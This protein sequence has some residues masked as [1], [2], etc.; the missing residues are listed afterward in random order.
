MVQVNKIGTV[1]SFHLND[2]TSRAHAHS[3]VCIELELKQT[4]PKMRRRAVCYT[5][6]LNGTV[7]LFGNLVF[8]ADD[9]GKLFKMQHRLALH[10]IA[11]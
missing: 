11:S 8:L 9:T 3:N 4:T 1:L 7:I 10:V 6:T 5:V 2:C